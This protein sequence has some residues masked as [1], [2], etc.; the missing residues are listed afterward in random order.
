MFKKQFQTKFII[1]VFLFLVSCILFLTPVFAT[2][3]NDVYPNCAANPKV[4]FQG[5]DNDSGIC[6]S[7]YNLDWTSNGYPGGSGNPQC[8]GDD[9]LENFND[10]KTD[11][12]CSGN[13][14]PS[15]TRSSSDVACCPNAGSGTFCV[16]NGNCYD[17]TNFLTVSGSKHFCE[18][19]SLYG[20]PGTWYDPDTMRLGGGEDVLMCEY[21][22]G[23]NPANAGES[24]VGEYSD[25]TTLECCGDDANEYYAQLCPGVSGSRKCCN[26]SG[27]KVD[28]SG[29]CVSSCPEPDLIIVDVWAESN[30]CSGESVSLSA[31]VRNQGN[32]SAGSSTT[33]LTLGSRNCNASTNSI[34]AG[35]DAIVSC[36]IITYGSGSQTLIGVA[37]YNTDVSESNE[38]NN[39]YSES[40]Y[41]VGTAPSNISNLRDTS[42]TAS[43]INWDWDDSSGADSYYIY[44]NGSYETTQALSSYNATNLICN[45]T[46]TITVIA[47]NSCGDSSDSNDS[48]TTNQFCN[49]DDSCCESN[50]C[51]Y[52]DSDDDCNSWYEY[53]CNNGIGCGDDV[54]R[55]V[56]TQYCTGSSSSCSGSTTTGNWSTY[57][58]CNSTETCSIGDSSCNYTASCDNTAPSTPSNLSQSPGS[59]GSWTNDS[60]PYFDFT[61]SDPDSGDTVGYLIQIDNNSNFSSPTRQYDWSGSTINPNNVRYTVP[62][63]LSDGSYYWRVRAEDDD[64]LYSSWA[65]DSNGFAGS[66]IDF[67]IDTVDPVC[68]SWSP[69]SP[70]WIN[71]DQ[72]FTLTGSTDT[73]S[74]INVSGGTCSV[75]VNGGTC[76]VVISDNAGNTRSCTSPVAKIGKTNP[77]VSNAT[78]HCDS[79]A[80]TC[81][82][83]DDT[84]IYFTWDLSDSHLVQVL[85]RIYCLL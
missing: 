51:S 70:D 33:R 78:A 29:N 25:T 56:I 41:N 47:H 12:T 79:Y 1:P 34:N 16:Y 67:R 15:F 55:R 61:I 18:T 50:G 20:T 27:D 62:S 10:R 73:S 52:K 24:N 31:R 69:S 40:G 65:N 59:E 7:D 21:M 74:G 57:D 85:D 53:G 2:D 49:P 3:D 9:S 30:M 23:M 71:T 66:G 77:S 5:C 84:E 46:Y 19:T 37:D 72:T 32:A 6:T 48:A 63:S 81:E 26:S 36:S 35:S 38:D 60:T 82:T 58:N 76:S 13:N 4:G 17:Y 80:D 68:G 39:T 54:T 42:R 28:A 45:T 8:C 43:S 75:S 22:S 11:K 44:I 14:C 64:N 83:D